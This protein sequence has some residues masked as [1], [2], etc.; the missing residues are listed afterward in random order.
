[1]AALVL[2]ETSVA[3]DDASAR[4]VERLRASPALPLRALASSSVASARVVL[5]PSAAP[6]RESRVPAAEDAV[7]RAEEMVSRAP[8]IFSSRSERLPDASRRRLPAPS[9]ASFALALTWSPAPCIFSITTLLAVATKVSSILDSIVLA[10]VSVTL[11]A[12]GLSFSFT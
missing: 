6:A 3:S 4:V 9:A 7:V 11:G 5:A 1:M 8:A 2:P 10:P 12:M